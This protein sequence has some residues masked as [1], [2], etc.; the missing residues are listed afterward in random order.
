VGGKLNTINQ[1][2][3]MIVPDQRNF[4]IAYDLSLKLVK[5]K[6]VRRE[7]I[8]EMCQLSG[9]QYNNSGGQPAICTRYLNRDFR[10][11]VPEF[12]V[13]SSDIQEVVENRDQLL[14]LHY[15]ERARG[16]LLTKKLIAFQELKEGAAYF[17]SFFQR[18]I[19][20]LLEYFGPAPERLFS[21]AD[22]IGGTKEKF[23]DAAVVIPAFSLVPITYIVWKGDDEFP[24]NASILFDQTINDYLATEDISVLCQTI[25]WK[26]LRSISS[27]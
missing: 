14:I 25:T 2:K 17:P 11:T 26:L 12:S 27:L 5:E 10:I 4:E 20:P 24:S 23:G 16:T 3:G 9:S 15:L 1:L 7:D 6:L 13:N 8:P 21:A 19:K 18:T 22:K